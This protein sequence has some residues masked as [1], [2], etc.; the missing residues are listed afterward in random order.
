MALDESVYARL[1]AALADADAHFASD[2]PGESG[3]R[4]PVHTVYVPADQ[5]TAD[6]PRTWGALAL[7]ALDAH[8]PDAP[9]LAA[10]LDVELA[11][12]EEVLPRVRA[13]LAAEPV[14]DLRIDFEDGYG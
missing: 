2:Y 5:F 6:L 13:K 14:E 4:A 12:A 3:A 10:I 11:L 1:D 8:C 7:T 9:A